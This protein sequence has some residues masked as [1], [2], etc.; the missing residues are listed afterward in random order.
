[1]F[2]VQIGIAARL[3]V[4]VVER[5][6]AVVARY[7]GF[8]HHAAALG[9][10]PVEEEGGD[11]RHGT[12]VV[13]FAAQ[14]DRHADAFGGPPFGR[15]MARQFHTVAVVDVAFVIGA[16]V[17]A[18]DHRDMQRDVAREEPA[19]ADVVFGFE[20]SVRGVQITAAQRQVALRS[21]RVAL[22]EIVG[23]SGV[24]VAELRPQ[25]EPLAQPLPRRHGAQRLF[26]LFIEDRHVVAVVGR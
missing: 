7:G 12:A 9:D 19:P 10:D 23:R 14:V 6:I 22:P 11:Q 13:E 8:E 1:M 18:I 24:G 20:L 17:A 3:I 21:L 26:A 15:E 25:F 16:F 5:R 4:A 2:G